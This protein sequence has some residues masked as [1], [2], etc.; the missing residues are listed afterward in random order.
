MS[1]ISVIIL[2]VICSSVISVNGSL[3]LEG[4]NWKEGTQVEPLASVLIDKP[5]QLDAVSFCFKFQILGRFGMQMG[6][7]AYKTS[8][9]W[10][11]D[12]KRSLAWDF[13][14]V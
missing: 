7:S 14:L 3:V 13:S 4:I 11:S 1:R 6:F 9:K 12:H 2:S 8:L 10:L 5:L